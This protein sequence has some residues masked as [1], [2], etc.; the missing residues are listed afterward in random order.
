MQNSR[1]SAQLLC[2]TSRTDDLESELPTAQDT[3]ARRITMST[4]DDQK[5]GALRPHYSSQTVKITSMLW[6]DVGLA[7]SVR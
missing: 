2:D 1:G 5:R 4:T 3:E 6:L 7:R